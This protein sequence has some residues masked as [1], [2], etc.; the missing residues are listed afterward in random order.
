MKVVPF[1]LTLITAIASL[2]LSALLFFSGRATHELQEKLAAQ[3]RTIQ[4][5]AS[6]AQIHQRML[7]DLARLSLEHPKIKELLEKNGYH[8]E[9]RAAQTAASQPEPAPAASPEPTPETA[10]AATPEPTATPRSSRNNN[11]SRRS[12]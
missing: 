4:Q 2:A 8:V 11:S 1:S 7:G 9:R 10:P 5:G 12:R 6:S 3:N